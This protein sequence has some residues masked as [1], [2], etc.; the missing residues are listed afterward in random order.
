MM[1]TIDSIPHG[2]PWFVR[3]YKICQWEALAIAIRHEEEKELTNDMNMLE[4]D[5]AINALK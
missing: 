1:V 4:L 2:W 3:N 5:S